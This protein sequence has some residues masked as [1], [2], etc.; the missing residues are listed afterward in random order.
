[1]MLV[2][3]RPLATSLYCARGAADITFSHL[4]AQFSGLAYAKMCFQHLWSER[5]EKEAKPDQFSEEIL[6]VSYYLKHMFLW[7]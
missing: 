7:R 3:S 4:S 5:V 1:M 2:R 6:E